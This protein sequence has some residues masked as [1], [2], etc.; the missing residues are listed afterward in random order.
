MF[1]LR[2]CKLNFRISDSWPYQSLV[3]SSLGVQTTMIKLVLMV[4]LVS[5]LVR[6]SH[7]GN[8]CSSLL[9]S[10]KAAAGNVSR[11]DDDPSLQL[12]S[13][14]DTALFTAD[15]VTDVVNGL[16]LYWGPSN[17]T[18]NETEGV[19]ATGIGDDIALFATDVFNG[20]DWGPGNA[21]MDDDT[22]DIK[23]GRIRK[24]HPIWGISM[25]AIPF[26][27]MMIVWFLIP[28]SWTKDLK[29][30]AWAGAVLFS[31]PLCL[32]FSAVAT[33]ISILMVCGF[34]IYGIIRPAKFKPGD[35]KYK[36]IH[37]I[38]KTAEISVESAIQTCLGKKSILLQLKKTPPQGST[39]CSS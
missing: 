33:P 12:A 34:G 22:E 25:M 26:L 13:L 35:S 27:P 39:L 23:D 5:V 16:N 28:L 8:C 31:I 21:T 19:N 4:T 18:V 38:L 36:H 10:A 30:G 6:P 9:N 37:G 17:A 2:R 3:S 14:L 29:G 11:L 32:P 15:V 1:T 20:L 24:A 7:S